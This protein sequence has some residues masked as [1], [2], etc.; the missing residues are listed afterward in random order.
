MTRLESG[1]I[2]VRAEATDLTDVIGSALRRASKVLSTHHVKVDMM[3]ELPMPRL[4]GVLLEQV[5]FNL[6]DNAAKYAPGNSEVCVKATSDGALVRVEVTDEG[7][8]IPPGDLE[9]IFDKFYRV[10]AADRR[11]AGTGLGLAICRGFIETM[12]GTITAGNRTDRPGAIFTV[13]L[14]VEANAPRERAA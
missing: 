14:P 9:R 12:G 7:E 4:D 5:I 6:L 3:P 8:G 1:A 2:S 10:H 11:R 13:T